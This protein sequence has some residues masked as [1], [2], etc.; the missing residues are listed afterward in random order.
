MYLGN[1]T[2]TG[3]NKNNKRTTMKFIFEKCIYYCVLYNIDK[4]QKQKFEMGDV[5]RDNSFNTQIIFYDTKI[6]YTECLLF[7]FL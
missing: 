4:A 7:F 1:D 6:F 2:G 3:L 5:G